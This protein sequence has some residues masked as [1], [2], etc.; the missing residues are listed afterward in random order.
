MN[1]CS[2]IIRPLFVDVEKHASNSVLGQARPHYIDTVAERLAD[3]H[4]DRPA[5]FHG[6]DVLAD[7]FP[8]LL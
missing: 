1:P 2:R 7:A 3:R 5:E 8:I 6:L 4:C